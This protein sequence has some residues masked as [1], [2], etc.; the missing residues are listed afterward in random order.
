MPGY[1]PGEGAQAGGY[2]GLC[3]FDMDNTLTRDM[4]STT[5]SCGRKAPT[6]PSWRLPPHGILPVQQ[7][8][9]V[10]AR[11]AISDC[12]SHGFAVGVA[13]AAPCQPPAALGDPGGKKAKS[14]LHTRMT[15]L[16]DLG[17]PPN[18][19][20]VKGGQGPAY[21]CIDIDGPGASK[22]SRMVG[23]LMSYYNVPENKTVFFDDQQKFLNEVKGVH[24]QVTTQLASSREC[25]GKVCLTACGLRKAEFDRGIGK[26]LLKNDPEGAK[27]LYGTMTGSTEK[28]GATINS[29]SQA[30]EGKVRRVARE[31]TPL[32]GKL[33]PSREQLG[34]LGHHKG[35]LHGGSKGH[36]QH[37]NH[38]HHHHHP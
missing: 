12:L 19:V 13:T 10:Y 27:K 17:M 1:H 11:Q 23:N 7:Y 5:E 28:G 16:K 8:P 18:V 37:H 31:A 29:R 4:L 2:K 26:V 9:A 22:K 36:Q 32:T 30:E 25:H 15:F 34:L 38:H 20:D 14:S 33:G 3:V 35:G 24:P 6:R 21:Q